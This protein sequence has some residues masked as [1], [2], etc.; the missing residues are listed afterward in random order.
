MKKYIKA[1]LFLAPSFVVMSL[2]FFYPVIKII[3]GSFYNFEAKIPRFVG[4]TNFKIIFTDE[5]FW[6]S[7]KNN[8]ILMVVGI[9][10]M[11]FLSLILAAFLYDRIKFWK[12]YRFI[13]FIPYVI[14]I[15]V[16]AVAFSYILTLH[17]MLNDILSFLHLNF[18]IVDWFAKP[19]TALTTIIFVVI[20]KELG[21]GI[22][23]MFARMLSLSED[24]FE[25]AKIDG[26][27]WWQI[28]RYVT[29]P[30]LRNVIEFYMVILVI[31]MFSWVFNYVYVMTRGGPGVSTWVGEMYV[32]NAAFRNYYRGIAY[33]S[34]FVIFIITLIFIIIQ[35]RFR[36]NEIDEAINI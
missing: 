26:A 1:Y 23:L 10:I 35:L 2:I 21:F 24:L 18:L 31:T 7:I 12:T 20:W 22:I 36:K 30:Q 17:G 16:I 15:T 8:L 27:S 28:F 3:Q 5:R 34:S 14:P 33:A 9:P 4:V 25:A 13:S 6:I 19:I 32:Y 29:I 11:V